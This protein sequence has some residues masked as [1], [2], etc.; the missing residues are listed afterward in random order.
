MAGGLDACLGPGG[1]GRHK[2]ETG[3]ELRSWLEE[4]GDTFVSPMVGAWA[5]VAGR[6]EVTFTRG[7][8]KVTLRSLPHGVLVP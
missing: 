3:V 8:V 2:K 6:Q 7:H 5:R 1:T 4:L